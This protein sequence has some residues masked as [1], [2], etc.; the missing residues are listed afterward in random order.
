MVSWNVQ[1]PSLGS[2]ME[3]IRVISEKVDWDFV[4]LQETVAV[5]QSLLDNTTAPG[6]HQIIVNKGKSFDTSIVVHK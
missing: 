5:S 1:K 3:T 6:G 4:L 2:L